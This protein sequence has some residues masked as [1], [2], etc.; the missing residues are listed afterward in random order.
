MKIREELK[1]VRA[2]KRWVIIRITKI[3]RTF[4]LR[5]RLPGS[6]ASRLEAK[7]RVAATVVLF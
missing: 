4:E 5:L 3:G 1:A 2:G 6:Y 7:A